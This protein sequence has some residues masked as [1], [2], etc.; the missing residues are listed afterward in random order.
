[1]LT[2]VN[3]I[4]SLDEEEF[5]ETFAWIDHRSYEDEVVEGVAEQ[6]EE[7][8]SSVW[9]DDE[10]WVNWQGTEY[11]IPLT[12]TRHDRYVAISSLAELLKEKYTFW[13]HRET[14]EDDTHGLLV[15]SNALADELVKNHADWVDRNLVRLQLGHDYFNGLEI[16]YYGHEN[17]NPDFQ[18]EAEEFNEA[19]AEYK[20]EFKK[21]MENNKEFQAAMKDMRSEL[22]TDALG[23]F[24]SFLR[25]Y[26]LLIVA[27][28]WLLYRWY[29]RN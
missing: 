25:Q 8:L 17:H 3:P 22:G 24:K 12:V 29:V 23:R 28:I 21:A 27:V 4:I 14:L 15:T 1:M 19:L 11:K 6:I 26:W 18:K 20:E 5:E 2:D 13:L 9:K 10:L 16:P 7:S